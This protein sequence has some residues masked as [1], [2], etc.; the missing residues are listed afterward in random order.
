MAGISE[1][2]FIA[3]QCLS[4][5]PGQISHLQTEVT[6]EVADKEDKNRVG[7]SSN[8]KKNLSWNDQYITEYKVK[9]NYTA[10]LTWDWKLDREMYA[11][12][13]Q[14]GRGCRLPNSIAEYS[15]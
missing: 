14:Q 4:P 10:V 13:K 8:F 15:T 7:F 12:C 6:A 2:D 3:M 11:P 5:Q 9:G 1:K